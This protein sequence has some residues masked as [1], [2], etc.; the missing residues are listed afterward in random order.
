MR[1]LVIQQA[2]TEGPGHIAAALVEQGATLDVRHPYRG[3]ALPT[4]LAD[5]EL[6]VVLG[7]PQHAWDTDRWPYLRDELSLLAEAA[8]RDLP[9]I[10]I[11]LGAQ[12]LAY[13]LGAK[14]ARGPAPEIGLT[15]L[16]ATAA[17]RQRQSLALLDGSEV[18]QWHEDAFELPAGAT[19]L[20]STAQYPNQA[21]SLGRNVVAVQFHPEVDHAIRAQWLI[22]GA[23][24]LAHVEP[25]RFLDPAI[26]ARHAAFAQA[27]VTELR[28]R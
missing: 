21:F 11:C 20:G 12:L 23:E 16:H 24:E 17:G 28:P 18:V 19:L 25:A 8:R 7:G 13:A 10:A 1:A 4:S 26:D 3:D 27:L 6:L 9:T 14:V 15:V 22:E 5:H 2:A